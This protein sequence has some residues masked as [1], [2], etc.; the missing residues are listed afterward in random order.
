M[1]EIAM[2]YG[3]YDLWVRMNWLRRLMQRST[4]YLPEFTEI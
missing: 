2:G 4:V 1:F 3:S